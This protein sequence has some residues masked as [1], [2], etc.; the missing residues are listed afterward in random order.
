VTAFGR[1]DASKLI[2][3]GVSQDTPSK[4]GTESSYRVISPPPQP[5]GAALAAKLAPMVD[6]RRPSALLAKLL[7]AV[8]PRGAGADDGDVDRGNVQGAEWDTSGAFAAIRRS[9]A[10]PDNE[11]VP[12]PKPRK[13]SRPPP[14]VTSF[15]KNRS[16]RTVEIN[17]GEMSALLDSSAEGK[18]GGFEG[19]DG[20]GDG[21]ATPDPPPRRGGGGE[22][23]L[24]QLKS[25]ICAPSTTSKESTRSEESQQQKKKQQPPVVE[26]KAT[27]EG[28]S[29]PH[30]WASFSNNS[31]PKGGYT[32]P[33]AT[34]GMRTGLHS[35]ITSPIESPRNGSTTESR[36]GNKS[37]EFS[38]KAPVVDFAVRTCTSAPIVGST[39]EKPPTIKGGVPSDADGSS[40][41]NTS[42]TAATVIGSGT[43]PA[44]A[45][46]A[47]PASMNGK[48]VHQRGER[49]AAAQKQRQFSRGDALTHPTEV[50]SKTLKPQAQNSDLCSDASSSLPTPAGDRPELS[51]GDEL[52]IPPAAPNAGK[53]Q[54]LHHRPPNTQ[55][56]MPWIRNP[57]S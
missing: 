7:D 46:A 49:D 35:L 21:V 23:D 55:D 53:V 34:R 42:S 10:C 50:L 19:K 3:P 41:H 57:K 51:G 54:A 45:S 9:G 39:A 13:K 56:S 31:S 52:Y 33:M 28:S 14:S 11:T 17:T 4:V 26:S 43:G 24:L 1:D 38:A 48:H 37:F 6:E 20:A 44:C 32:S 36:T 16:F 5:G 29:S 30:K 12:S 18:G 47:T 40:T 25:P 22:T 2:H 8:V 27:R 15:E